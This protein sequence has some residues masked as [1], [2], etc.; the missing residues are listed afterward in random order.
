M[1]IIGEIIIKAIAMLQRSFYRLRSTMEAVALY[2]IHATADDEK[3]SVFKVLPTKAAGIYWYTLMC[4][5][6]PHFTVCF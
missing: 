5:Y 6:N 4:A 2:D 3:G 1:R